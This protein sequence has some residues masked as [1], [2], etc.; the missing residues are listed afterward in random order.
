MGGE[1]VGAMS[2]WY[3]CEEP[4]P[5]QH[6]KVNYIDHFDARGMRRVYGRGDHFSGG[7]TLNIDVW[8]TKRGR[9]VARF[10]SR[11]SEVDGMSLEVTGFSTDLL[12]PSKLAGL[13]ERWVPKCL[14]DEYDT[15][16][17]T[18]S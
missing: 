3:I 18:E 6:A 1:M 12:L 11:S 16:V 10:W 14:R 5:A 2:T 4:F 15:W 13:D 9:L 17:I 7:R 8:L